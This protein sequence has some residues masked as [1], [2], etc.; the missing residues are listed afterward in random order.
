MDKE[1]LGELKSQIVEENGSTETP[2]SSKY[3]EEV[4][5]SSLRTSFKSQDFIHI[6][7]FV[8]GAVDGS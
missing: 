6:F 7:G 1:V 4:R 3:F 2:Y 5:T 8:Y